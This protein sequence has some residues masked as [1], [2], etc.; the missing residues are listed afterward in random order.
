[1]ISRSKE[2]ASR[3]APTA[4]YPALPR[5]AP[6]QE[7]YEGNISQGRE[8]ENIDKEFLR[9][10][11]TQVILHSPTPSTY[12]GLNKAPPVRCTPPQYFYYWPCTRRGA[13]CG[14]CSRKC[15]SI[16]SLRIPPGLFFRL[17]YPTTLSWFLRRWYTRMCNARALFLGKISRRMITQIYRRVKGWSQCGQMEVLGEENGTLT[18]TTTGLTT[19]L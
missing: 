2:P 5:I 3:P 11:Y 1:M 8:P 6:H 4:C 19:G 9:R 10:W 18:A 17:N 15:R 14:A 12:S 7:T 13:C 16:R